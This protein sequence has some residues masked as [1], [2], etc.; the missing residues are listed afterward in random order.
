M[1]AVETYAPTPESTRTANLYRLRPG[2]AFADCWARPKN[3]ADDTYV[4]T[5]VAALGDEALLVAG[6]PEPTRL[7][8][9][10]LI[11]GLTGTS[12]DFRG[13]QSSVILFVRVGQQAFALTF[14]GGW[15]M[16]RSGAVDHDF[17]LN[18]ALRVLDSGAVRTI[19]RTHFGSKARVDRNTVPGGTSLWSFGIREHAELVGQ[20]AG[21]IR[22]TESLRISQ[23]RKSERRITIDCTKRVRLPIPSDRANLIDDL[24]EISR[25]APCAATSARR[26]NSWPYRHSDWPTRRDSPRTPC[27]QS[28]APTPAPSANERYRSSRPDDYRAD[29]AAP[30]PASPT[31]PEPSLHFIS[32][33]DEAERS[34]SLL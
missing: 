25:L 4:A 28:T 10:A 26:S 5:P 19:S 20:I 15:R 30:P 21:R 6:S 33:Q 7:A 22:S 13:G 23:V 27:W 1:T 16:L 14:G 29:S 17:G 9:V 32:L 18:L 2:V 3:S 31:R 11:E 34:P 12:L 8:W 24:R